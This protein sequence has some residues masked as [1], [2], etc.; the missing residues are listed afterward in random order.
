MA[1]IHDT[2]MSPGKLELLTTWL[3]ARPAGPA[4]ARPFRRLA[5]S[6]RHPGPRHPRDRGTHARPASRRS[7][8]IAGISAGRRSATWLI[9]LGLPG[10][11]ALLVVAATSAAVTTSRPAAAARSGYDWVTSWSASPQ[12]PMPGT[13]GKAGFH[14]QTVRDIIFPSVGGNTI[15]LELT[16]AF[17]RSPLQVGRVTVAVAGLGAGSDPGHHPPGELRRPRVGPDPGRRAGPQRPGGHAGVGPAGTGGEHLPAGPD[18]CGHRALGRPAGQLGVDGRR[19][20]RRGGG[21]RVH[22]PDPVLVLPQ[23]SRRAVVRSGRDRGRVR[24]LDHRRRAV[25]RR[26]QR[27]LAQRPG[28]ETGHGRLVRRSRWSTR[29]S[30]A[31]GC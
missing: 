3:P 4:A 11:L 1:I 9:R 29:G 2:T 5:S 22:D 15:R 27:P 12:D 16:N 20:R 13:L 6:G 18:R 23:R 30:A 24:R 17:G 10:A 21:G 7:L 26:R 31:T 25:D 28:P 19:P 8:M 14:D